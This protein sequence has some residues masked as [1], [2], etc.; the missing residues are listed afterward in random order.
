MKLHRRKTSHPLKSQYRMW[1]K[2][3]KDGLKVRILDYPLLM[4]NLKS[5][6]KNKMRGFRTR[7]KQCLG[8]LS[9]LSRE[10]W[11]TTQIC[12]TLKSSATGESNKAWWQ[13]NPKTSTNMGKIKPVLNLEP[14]RRRRELPRVSRIKRKTPKRPKRK[15]MKGLKRRGSCTPIEILGNPWIFTCKSWWALLRRP[16]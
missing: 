8:L 3:A 14:S 16:S 4:W 2:T 7:S 12:I 11:W 1:R 10:S 6:N 5:V 9:R 15:K 13:N